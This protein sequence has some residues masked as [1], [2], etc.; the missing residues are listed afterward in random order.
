MSSAST[1]ANVTATAI[2]NS[3]ANPAKTDPS[4]SPTANG[5]SVKE[6]RA[7]GIEESQE[8][9]Q[10]GSVQGGIIEGQRLEQVDDP[11]TQIVGGSARPGPP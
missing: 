3:A 5:K 1:S 7:R 9:E 8:E 10:S 11:G 4:A 2:P 6:T